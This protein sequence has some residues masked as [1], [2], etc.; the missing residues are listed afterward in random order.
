MASGTA[1]PF[2]EVECP[3]CHAVIPVT[4]DVSVGGGEVLVEANVADVWAHAWT[5]TA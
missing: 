3:E 5:H 2:L 4:M 1:V